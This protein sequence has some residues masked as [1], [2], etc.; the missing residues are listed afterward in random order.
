MLMF[1]SPFTLL[2]HSFYL[3]VILEKVHF[4]PSPILC[5]NFILVH[6]PGPVSFNFDAVFERQIFISQIHIVAHFGGRVV[7][8]GVKAQS[9][10]QVPNVWGCD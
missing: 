3:L 8:T 9:I 5:I 4:S 1:S 10:F 6:K 7:G 2:I